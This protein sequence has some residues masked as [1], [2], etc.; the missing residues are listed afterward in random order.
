MNGRIRYQPEFDGLRAVAIVPVVLFHAG[1]PGIPGGFVGVDVF[2]VISGFLISRLLLLELDETGRIDFLAFYARRARRLLPALATVVAAVLVLGSFILSPALER[3]QLSQ[4][5]TA[6]MA[7]VSNIYFWRQQAQYFAQP[8]EWVPLL[9]MWTLSV[10]EQFYLLWPALLMLAAL[11]ARRRPLPAKVA[12]MLAGLSAVSFA[13]FW[14]GVRAEPTASYY[15][16]PTR[17]WEFALGAA[18]ALFEERLRHVGRGAAPFVLVG[19]MAVALAVTLG[20]H[21]LLWVIGLAAFGT[22]AVIGGVTAAPASTAARL[23]RLSPLVVIGKLSY[24]W[25]LWHWPLLAFGRV[26][27]AGHHSLSRNLLV[28]FGALALAALTF[29]FIEDPIR[30]RRPWPFSG[31]GQTLATGGAISLVLVASALALAFQAD[32]AMRRDPWLAAIDAAGHGAVHSPP[33]C[34]AFKSFEGLP[35]ARHCAVGAEKAPLRILLW[36]DSQARQ[37]VAVLRAEGT[38]GGY[39]AVARSRTACPPLLLRR[40]VRLRAACRDFNA[41]V[42]AELPALRHAGVGGVIL[43]SRRFGV[44]GPR[45]PAPALKNWQEGFRAIL[46]VARRLQMRVL[47]VAPIPDFQLALPQC[48]AHA[49]AVRCGG[50]RAMFEQKRAPVLAALREAIAGDDDARLWDPFD[51]LCD[52]RVC[53]PVRNGLIMYSN[54]GHLSVQGSRA[55]A[56]FIAPQLDWLL[57]RQ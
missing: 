9:N 48:L 7:F 22:A 13:L 32:A 28:A 36:G 44:S 47:V 43:A 51:L 6:T 1:V 2:F 38:R 53:T 4:S 14:W 17:A 31:A 41:A 54:R 24:S 56:P 49:S 19:L 10:E 26:L 8:S 12:L 30:R 20:R 15:L 33:G 50:S 34:H 42:A 16:A 3:P 23:L 37:L 45:A 27:D 39:A 21:G 46:S 18:L 25:Y 40:P 29:V 35:P 11:F 5:A 57:G 55:L 52:A